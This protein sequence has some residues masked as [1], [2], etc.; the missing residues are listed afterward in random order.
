MV[1][2]VLLYLVE[3]PDRLSE[4]CIEPLSDSIEDFTISAKNS[5]SSSPNSDLARTRYLAGEYKLINSLLLVLEHGKR[6]KCLADAA[7][8]RCE[9]VQNLRKAIYDFKMKEGRERGLNYLLRYFYLI[10]FAEY[11]LEIKAGQSAGSFAAWLDERREITNMV[12]RR[13]HIDFS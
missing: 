12:A 3:H 7:I 4:L 8:D 2:V 11:L 10:A 6:A 13:E 9:A 1:I 5:S